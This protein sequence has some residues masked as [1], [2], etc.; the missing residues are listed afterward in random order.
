MNNFNNFLNHL[1]SFGSHKLFHSRTLNEQDGPIE[2]PRDVSPWEPAPIAT[3]P[4]KENCSDPSHHHG[5]KTAPI[6]TPI[7]WE[8]DGQEDGP[9]EP[10]RDEKPEPF[11]GPPSPQSNKPSLSPSPRSQRDNWNEDPHFYDAETIKAVNRANGV[12]DVSGTYPAAPNRDPLPNHHGMPARSTWHPTG[13]LDGV[14]T[15]EGEEIEESNITTFADHMKFLSFHSGKLNEQEDASYDDEGDEE[16][17]LNDRSSEEDNPLSPEAKINA[18][19]AWDN[20]NTWYAAGTIKSSWNELNSLQ[21][22]QIKD[23]AKQKGLNWN[24][25]DHLKLNEITNHNIFLNHLNLFSK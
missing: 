6:A 4:C 8:E 7:D 13:F 19:K 18:Q 3:P 11:V 23:L 5:S 1:N 21:K 20:R 12:E 24:E 17:I 10:P 15:H 25:M 2:P 9:I 22:K 16:V 14:L